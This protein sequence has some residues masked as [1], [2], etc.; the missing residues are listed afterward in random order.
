MAARMLSQP[1]N[2]PPG[3]FG[4]PLVG[5]L[6]AER[7]LRPQPPLDGI[8]L[9]REQQL[10]LLG[11][12]APHW[13]RFL[14]NRDQLRLYRPV[15]IFP[16]TDATVYASVIL[17]NRPKRIIE[18]GS[19]YSSALALDVCRMEGLD[20]RL[21]FIEPFPDERLTGL[22][23]GLA[24]ERFDIRPMPVQDVPLTLFD[25]LGDGDILFVDGSHIVKAGSDTAWV[26]FNVLPRLASGVVVQIHDMFWPFE[27]PTAWLRDGR[28]FNEIY[29]VRA[30][31]E[32]NSDF[33]IELFTNWAWR[34]CP[35][36]FDGLRAAVGD[37]W[38]AS[39]YLRRV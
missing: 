16:L 12:L 19:G 10:A 32:F 20:T 31:L 23:A 26:V 8:D 9:R 28:S 18:I 17:H 30:F 11:A 38:P 29:L 14:A 24:P 3:H 22:V 7:A 1:L 25:E 36:E 6:D 2:S 33:R 27:Y 15:P 4:S 37:A 35:T 5:D 13:E 21:T 34:E 39:L